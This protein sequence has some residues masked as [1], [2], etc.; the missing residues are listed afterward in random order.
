MKT[1]HFIFFISFLF[2]TDFM[3]AQ[4]DKKV[5]ADSSDGAALENII[6]E[7]YYVATEKDYKVNEGGTLAKGSVTYRIYVDL[8]PGYVLQAVFGSDKH[9]L[10]IET[11]TEFFNNTSYGATKGDFIDDKKL[12]ENTV[13]LD[14]WL[15]LGA[16]TRS[17][18][19]ILR[20]EDQ[21]GSI[22]KK[23]G[24][25][26][27]DGLFESEIKSAISFGTINFDSFYGKKKVSSVSSTNGS[28]AVYGG[29]KGP[30]EENKIL[31]AQLTTDGKL[32]FDLNIQIGKPNNGGPIQF[33]AHNQV[34]KE[35]KFDGLSFK[36]K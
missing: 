31:I 22:I 13:A 3:N 8:K 12:N 20:T 6:V 25:K 9:P 24:L 36:Q 18:N 1:K 15:T 7:Q 29:V 17:H 30:T 16:A 23:P 10:K 26:N 33:V 32:S 28:W 14:S 5:I 27:A 2:L 34:D 11:S 4:E 35:I 19:G 21:D